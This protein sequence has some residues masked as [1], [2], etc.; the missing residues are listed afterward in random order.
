MLCT[1]HKRQTP[2]LWMVSVATSQLQNSVCWPQMA[3]AESKNMAL[4]TKVIPQKAEAAIF[5]SMSLSRYR[6]LLMN[7]IILPSSGIVKGSPKNKNDIFLQSIVSILHLSSGEVIALNGLSHPVLIFL[8]NKKTHQISHLLNGV[9][10][11]V[12]FPLHAHLFSSLRFV[13]LHLAVLF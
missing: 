5:F 4:H 1:T 9:V 7:Y 12:F 2:I 13:V 8:R 11:L 6:Y 3:L 10:R